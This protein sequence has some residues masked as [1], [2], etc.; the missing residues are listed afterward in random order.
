MQRVPFASG[1]AAFVLCLSAASSH[2]QTSHVPP[3]VIAEARSL[4]YSGAAR[5]CPADPGYFRGRLSDLRRVT[6]PD[7]LVG[8]TSRMDNAD[9][10]PAKVLLER[11]GDLTSAAAGHILATGNATVAEELMNVLTHWARSGAYVNTK[12]CTQNG[13]LTNACSAWTRPDGRDLSDSM[14]FSTVQM[15]MAGARSAYFGTIA[16]YK[17]SERA[18]DHD[19]IRRWFAVFDARQKSPDQ[20]YLGLKVGWY[21]PEIERQVTEG[22]TRRARSLTQKM[23]RDLDRLMLSDGSIKDRTTRGDRALWYHA[24]AI[25]EI[26]TAMEMAR[27]LQVGLPAGM[28]NK[29]HQSVALFVR[30]VQDPAA[31]DPWAR[32]AHNATYRPNQQNYRRDFWQNFFGHSWIHV[33]A[34]RYPEQPAAQWLAS[35]VPARSQSAM[36]DADIGI[37]IGCIYEA[38]RAAR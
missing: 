13:R 4:G 27:T 10:I 3:A 8:L 35:R 33:Y 28:E 19:A 34:Y 11:F 21:W 2:A 7:R 37:A 38:A 6:P 31:I 18:A 9:Q 23:L 20:V 5:Y 24:T 1:L 25:G 29:L 36:H 15:T 30:G 16:S 14:D 17:A 26:V 32:I 22:N 12:S